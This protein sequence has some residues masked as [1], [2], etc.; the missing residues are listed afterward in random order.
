MQRS[1]L[2]SFY[3]DFIGTTQ[4][5]RSGSLSRKK[6]CFYFDQ[7]RLL[8]NAIYKIVEV[9]STQ[10]LLRNDSALQCFACFTNNKF[11]FRA[12]LGGLSYGMLAMGSLLAHLLSNL[13]PWL[14]G[15]CVLNMVILVTHFIA[16][17][18][19]HPETPR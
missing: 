2:L 6:N 8:C 7:G 16:V 5:A 17:G 18:F 4:F 10:L 13:V 19:F 1:G 15:L 11:P 14:A 12:S 3:A 9:H